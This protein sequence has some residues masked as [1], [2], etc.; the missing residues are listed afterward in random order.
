MKI[1]F[2]GSMKFAVPI[3]EGLNKK[4]HVSLVVTQPDKPVGRKKI[5][6]PTPVK[7][8]ALELGL[9]VF[10]PKNIRKD[11]HKITELDLDFIIV[12][13]YG[14]MIPENVLNH[15]K[16]R[17]INVHA[18]LLPMYRGGSPMH[19][20][21]QYGDKETGITVMFMAMK[22]DAG[23]ILA[24]EK[25]VI[26]DNDNVG[27][28]EEK[29]SYIGR[30]LLIDTLNNIDIITP[31]KQ[32]ENKVT[33]AYNIKPEEE[34]L[35]FNKSAQEL[36]NHVRGFYPWPLTYFMINNT[37]IKVYDAEYQSQNISHNIGEIVKVDEAGVYI[38]TFDGLL[39]IKNLQL[40][41]KK[42][43]DIKDFM[44]GAGRNIF[45]VGNKVE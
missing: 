30:D 22:M 19:R 5:I 13:A 16:Y 32:D 31:V 39:I 23:E 4:Y 21:I 17:A 40:Q 8:K 36:Y 37:K 2:M 10:Q 18:S 41:G 35:D 3:L 1:C 24:Q 12:A 43:M 7:E 28:I 42:R 33:F 9:E 14:Q 26:N 29:L 20:A 15:A 44:N 38:Q 11:F 34:R 27:I 25:L 6:T 45:I